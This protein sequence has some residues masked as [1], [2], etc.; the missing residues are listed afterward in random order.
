MPICSGCFEQ[1]DENVS[2][3][4]CDYREN[5]R[6]SSLLLQQGT[7]LRGQ[8][9]MGNVLGNPGGFGIT[10]L[11]YNKRLECKV[12]IK[13]FLPRELAGRALDGLTVAVHRD[14]EDHIFR[15]GLNQFLREA[16]TLAKFNHPN[17][18]RVVDF[19]EENNTAY[20][21]MDYC[22][23]VNLVDYVEQNGGPLSEK[24]ALELLLP[25]FDGLKEVHSRGILHR[26]IKPRNVFITSN[27][28]PILLDFGAARQ[29]AESLSE[30]FTMLITPGFAPLEQYDRQGKQGP[31]TDVYA[32]AATLYYM[33]TGSIPPAAISRVANDTFLPVT[34]LRQVSPGIQQALTLGLAL[35]PE[36]RPQ[37]VAEF[38]SYLLDQTIKLTTD[39]ATQLLSTKPPIAFTPKQDPVED[40]TRETAELVQ[41][42]PRRRNWGIAGILVLLLLVTGYGYFYQHNSD[43]VN[44]LGKKGIALTEQAFFT[45]V[46]TDDQDSVKLFF[47]AGY[48]PNYVAEATGITPLMNAIEAGQFPMVKMLITYGASLDAKDRQGRQPIDIA[49]KQGNTQILKLLMDQNRLTPDSKDEQGATLLEK[50]IAVG[51][52]STIKFLLDQGATIN[53]QDSRGNTLLDRMVATGNQQIAAVLRA[54]GA[55]R[56]VNKDFARGKLTEL[57]LPVGD[58]VSFEIDL[59]G[60]GIGQQV[61]FK[62]QDQWRVSVTI[63][64]EGRELASFSKYRTDKW[65]VAYLRDDSVPDLVYFHLAGS[66]SYIEEVKIIGRI[67][68]E[69]IGILFAPEFGNLR[70]V[71]IIGG[72]S[73]LQ[74]DSKKLI[75]FSENGKNKVV[76]EWTPEQQSFRMR[77]L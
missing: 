12:A 13:E 15:A 54:A 43:P 71:G 31:W 58:A 69:S 57:A 3:P 35:L 60:N 5:I 49:L 10:Y 73:G 26:D 34:D 56:N 21:V 75:L 52:L 68:K 18:V 77:K 32:C 61:T 7:V 74:I 53:A 37:S 6:Q 65:Y 42:K 33:L 23:G 16:R 8:Y 2:C 67:G 47:A 51:N 63:S 25:I 27:G 19:F 38:Q 30:G 24:S 20:L 46:K 11:G 14:K 59:L 9:V 40:F 22:S 17:I 64:Q 48:S 36:H 4:Y 66:D 1:I 62:K 50:S 55:R 44:Q 76:V 72:R 29:A 45:A 41:A 28:R 39:Q 70:K